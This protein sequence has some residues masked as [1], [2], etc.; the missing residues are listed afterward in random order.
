MSN[1]S[2]FF[3]GIYF[4]WRFGVLCRYFLAVVWVF[5]LYIRNE[6]AIILVYKNINSLFIYK[7]RGEMAI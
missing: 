2:N 4:S 3:Y 6:E 5:V 1:P 7:S